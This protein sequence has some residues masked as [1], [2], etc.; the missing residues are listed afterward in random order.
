MGRWP[1]VAAKKDKNAKV[2][3]KINTMHAKLISLAAEKWSDP[4]LNTALTDAIHA[5]KKDGVTADVI[6]RAIARGAGLDKDAKK[7]EEIFY[8]GYA[9]GGVAVIARALTDNRNRTAP[10]IRHI[11]SAFGGNLGE[12]GSV[13]NFL[14]DYLGKIIITK[15]ENTDTFEEYI[16]ET[17]AED[18]EIEDTIITIWT[19][20]KSLID[21]KKA[22]T[23]QGYEIEEA[24]F[25]YRAKNYTP[26]TDFDTA[27]KLYKMFD[28]FNEDEDVEVIWNNAHIED[29]LWQEVESYVQE[30]KF[31]T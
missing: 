4:N 1:V 15:P 14:F 27:L 9:T 24:G 11:F 16:L 19:D 13:S 21:T 12:T 3:A 29:D 31:R 2:R 7:V 18:Y 25:F 10:N 28:E 26:I 20:T 23:D 22:L 5:A 6:D 17:A 8:E 30:R